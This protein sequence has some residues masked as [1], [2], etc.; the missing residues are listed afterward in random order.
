[1]RLTPRPF[2]PR[3]GSLLVL[4]ALAA[5]P[6]AEADAQAFATDDPILERMWEEGTENS[7][8]YSLGQTLMDS[9]GPRLTGSP[10][11]DSAHDWIVS[12]YESWGIEAENRQYGTWLGWQ[13]RF[14]HVDL[15]SPRPTSL[16]ARNLAWSPGTNGPVEGR[17]VTLPDVTDRDAFRAWME[18][19]VP[20]AFVLVSFP[21]PTC[22]PDDYWERHGTEASI[23]W[24]HEDR[25]DRE[26]NWRGRIQA[27]G[28]PSHQLPR[29]LELAG[30]AGILTSTWAGSWGTNRVFSGGTGEVPTLDVECEDYGLLARLAENG[31][32]PEIRVNVDAEFLDETPTFNTIAMIRGS[33]RPD[34]YVLL[35]AHLDTWSGATGAT[36]NGTGTITMME[37]MRILSETYPQP[38]RT[39][40]VGHWGGEEQGLNGS[41]AFAEDHPEILEGMQVVMNQDNG[42]GRIVDIGMQGFLQ[43]GGYFARW[44]ARVPGELSAPVELEIPGL[45]DEGRSDHAS[46][47]CHGVPSFRLGAHEWDYRD[48]TWHTNRDTF[49]KISIEEVRGNAILTAMLAYLASEEPELMSREK[50]ELPVVEEDNGQ[51]MQWPECR[52]PMRSAF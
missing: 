8:I 16:V 26:E 31:Q 27:S 50:R 47:V 35:S 40:I 22:R 37:A 12:T 33:E 21:P 51:R 1:M 42:T 28:V 23:A 30:A 6:A 39:I 19:E 18:E 49:D 36:D 5:G 44:L 38:R 41:A 20:G 45:P 9:I 32:G 43:A 11:L 25:E 24:M 3:P 2:D 4:L 7:R 10:G 52:E 48:Y 46:F 15:V 14:T 29:F 17:V 34:E 13:D